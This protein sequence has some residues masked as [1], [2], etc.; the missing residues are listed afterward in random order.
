MKIAIVMTGHRYD[1]AS[2]LPDELELPDGATLADALQ[3]LRAASDTPWPLAPTC[4]V[5]VSGRH[6]GT[7]AKHSPCVLSPGDEIVLIAPVAGG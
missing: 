4:L 1:R 5:A 3:T 7:L 2:A 6:L